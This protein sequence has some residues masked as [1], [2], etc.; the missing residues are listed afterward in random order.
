MLNEILDYSIISPKI[1]IISENEKYIF[2]KLG[3]SGHNIKIPKKINKK[4]AYL[5]GA[6][7]GDGSL[8]LV[9][10]REGTYPRTK[11]NIY[12]NSLDYL[13]ILDLSFQELFDVPTRI[14][15]KR[16]N[17]CY[18]LELNNKFVWLFFSKHLKIQGKKTNLQIPK[19][20]RN[21]GLFKHF[22]AGL[23]DTDGFYNRSNKVYGTMLCGSN[24]E[25]L[26]EINRLCLEYY[27]I[28]MLGPYKNLLKVGEKIYARCMITTKKSDSNLFRSIIPLKRCMGLAGIEPA[29]SALY[30]P[31]GSNVGT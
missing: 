16:Y 8:S 26:L 5:F 28:K 12:N 9:N 10:R 27:G 11:L 14:Y 13:K 6:I 25:F 4:I 23:F 31:S 20:V 19:E 21:K 3:A 17:N 7:V 29:T 30:S 24:Y 2:P 15:K 1:R 18:V 22:L